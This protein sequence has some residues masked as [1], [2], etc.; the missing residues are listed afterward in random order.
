MM[1]SF[2]GIRFAIAIMLALCV[3]NFKGAEAQASAGGVSLSEIEDYSDGMTDAQFR[4]GSQLFEETPGG[5][6]YLSYS[7][8]LP[9]DWSQEFDS[10]F[11]YN[12]SD[13][14]TG[15]RRMMGRII[16]YS[17]PLRMDASSVLEI[18]AYP[19]EFGMTARD[20]FLR[21]AMENG[22]SLQSMTEHSDLRTEVLYIKVRGDTGYIVRAMVDLN[23][24]RVIVTTY[25]VPDRYWMGE[26]G[27]QQKAMESLTFH[28]PEEIEVETT[29]S[30]SFLEILE[31]SYPANWRMGAP[32][33]H[34]LQGMDARLISSRDNV[35]LDAEIYISLISTEVNTT[36]KE[37]VLYMRNEAE[38]RGLNIGN[39]IERRDDFR[40]P[41]HVTQGNIEVYKAAQENTDRFEHELWV[42]V[43]IEPE[44]FYLVTLIT[45]G[46]DFEYFNWIRNREAFKT[47]VES[48]RPAP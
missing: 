7:I 24:P 3:L 44:F 16:T 37:E 29:N 43:I 41:S 14:G 8:R 48:I 38:G 45:P 39:M 9:N 11:L 12:D 36:L 1:N 30:Y 15:A 22:Y 5:D 6:K 33:I 13:E 18:Y 23:G 4:E 40:L 2:A 35:T 17:G 28:S 21:H 26:R 34:G 20:W 25:E 31:F 19:L 47:V 42:A 32:V 46:R 10:F 27:W